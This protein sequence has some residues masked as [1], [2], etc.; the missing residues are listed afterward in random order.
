MT[1]GDGVVG[2][3]LRTRAH[4]RV[5]KE[6]RLWPLVL[7]SVYAVPTYIA[8]RA[9]WLGGRLTVMSVGFVFLLP[10]AIGCILA[11]SMQGRAKGAGRGVVVIG[12]W[13]GALTIVG[14]VAVLS[15]EPLLFVVMALPVL[16]LMSG[17]GAA[18]MWAMFERVAQR[19]LRALVLALVVAAPFV[20]GFAE[21][22]VPP[23]PALRSVRTQIDIAADPD[24][25]WRNVTRV[26]AIQP[27]EHRF[28]ILHV[29]GLPRPRQAVLSHEGVGG[30]RDAQ[31]EQGLRFVEEVTHWDDRRDLRFTIEVDRSRTL[32]PLMTAIDGHFRVLE[33]HYSIEPLGEGRVRL[34]LVS[35]ERLDT[36]FNGYAGLWTDGVMRHL[37]TYILRIIKER[38]EAQASAAG[39]RHA[40]V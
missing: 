16:V 1:V 35:S 11:A 20:T 37:Q 4:M 10:F 24:V 30:V 28:S 19:S 31:F 40:A 21:S 26:P 34:H 23:A 32:S 33:G 9:G 27:A 2:S 15:G 7:A 6:S 5:A 14:T 13:L 8:F 39:G 25:T 22:L 38:C 3:S 18:L 17:L 29:L 12:T 36:R